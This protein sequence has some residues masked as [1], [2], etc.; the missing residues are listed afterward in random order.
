M[1]TGA[2]G[3]LGLEL[4][5][6]LAAHRALVV[7]AVRDRGRG[8]A[9]LASIRADVPSASILIEPL[10]LASLAS[11]R[12]FGDR[13]AGSHEGLDL[14]VNNAGVMALPRRR[15]TADGFEMQL[16][17]N[18]LGH[19]ALTAHLLPLLLQRAGSR[20]VTVSSRQHRGSSIDLGDLQSEGS[21]SPWRAYGSSKLANLLFAFE[22]QRRLAA[23]RTSTISLAAH[24]GYSAT[25]LQSSGPVGLAAAGMRIGNL[26]IAQSAAAGSLPILRASTDPAAD[27]GEFYGPSRWGGL[28]GAPV[29]ERADPAAYD[30]DLA[31]RLWDASIALTGADFGPFR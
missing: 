31:G 24:P 4:A 13:L 30:E 3:G 5:R 7:L 23:F 17:T 20:V 28:R 10:D 1:V 18:H 14:L 15:L 29:L 25:G 16:G 19:V 2:S 6:R 27:G 22:L 9:A 26:L 11:I 8:E 12:A 21:Y